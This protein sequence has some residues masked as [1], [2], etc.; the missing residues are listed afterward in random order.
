MNQDLKVPRI[1]INLDG[2]STSTRRQTPSEDTVQADH[3]THIYLPLQDPTLLHSWLQLLDKFLEF[4]AHSFDHEVVTVYLCLHVLFTM[5]E[6][7]RSPQA[8]GETKLVHD[9]TRELLEVHA[10]VLQSED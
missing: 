7:A 2:F 9:L 1:C 6:D 5:H 3:L 10:C 8:A 4:T